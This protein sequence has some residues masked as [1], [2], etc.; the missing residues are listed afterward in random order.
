MSEPK[1]VWKVKCGYAE[2]PTQWIESE[3]RLKALPKCER[4]TVTHFIEFSAYERV[5]KQRDEL[6]KECETLADSLSDKLKALSEENERLK[7]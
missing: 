4:D 2:V 6:D 5:V 1:Q 7:K 3:E